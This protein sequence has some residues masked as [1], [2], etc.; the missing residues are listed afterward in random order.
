MAL[1]SHHHPANPTTA[2]ATA[3]AAAVAASAAFLAASVNAFSV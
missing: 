1:Q 2:T 3:V